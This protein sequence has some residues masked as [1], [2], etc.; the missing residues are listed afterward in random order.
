M[1]GYPAA[2]A[3][4]IGDRMHLER[5]QTIEGFL[6][7][8]Q[9]FL[10]E[11]EAEHNLLLGISNT[12]LTAP[13]VYKEPPYLAVVTD[14]GAVVGAS[15][16]TRPWDVALSEMDDARAVD[17]FVEDRLGETLPGVFG[18]SALAARFADRWA[19]HTGSPVHLAMRE[20][21]FELSAVTPPRRAPGR[22]RPARLS[23]RELL[24]QWLGEFT[25]EA[26]G[27]HLPADLGELADRWAAG[28][29]RTMQLWIDNGIPVSMTGVGARTPHG[30]RIGPVYTPLDLRGRG[31]ASNLVAG[32]CRQE[33][34]AG[35]RFCFLFTDLSNPTSNHI[36]KAIGFEPV[37][38]VDRWSFE[39]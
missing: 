30:V 11:R 28:G 9:E 26:L 31:Y 29:N 35:R 4:T 36:Y 6:G 13:G 7:A 33:L 3:Q 22:M 23:D 32:A 12:L 38:D 1:R 18:P 27:G 16:Q 39:P 25:E 19:T 10:V 15:L 34:A 14:A 8:A 21:A 24:F 17:V 5:F 20:R 2:M 37:T